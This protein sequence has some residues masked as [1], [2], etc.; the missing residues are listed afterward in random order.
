MLFETR[1]VIQEV[2]F[3]LRRSLVRV[4]IIPRLPHYELA[5]RVR[6][7]T[8]FLGIIVNHSTFQTMRIQHA[9]PESSI[10]GANALTPWITLWMLVLRVDTH[11]SAGV[12]QE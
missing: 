5:R 7:E 4:I 9:S 11:R 10:R 3:V 2:S 12:S 6:I 8:V 1:P